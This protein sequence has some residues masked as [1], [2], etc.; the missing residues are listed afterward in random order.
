M[1][2][3]ALWVLIF[4]LEVLKML[5]NEFKCVHLDEDGECSQ[6]GGE[7]LR[8]DMCEDFG[9]CRTCQMLE[10]PEECAAHC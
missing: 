1:E 3:A 2:L 9:E 7:C 4:V 10:G 6:M 5:C 8:S